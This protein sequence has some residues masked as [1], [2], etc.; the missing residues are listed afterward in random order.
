MTRITALYRGLSPHQIVESLIQENAL[1]RELLPHER[2]ADR[3]LFP[4]PIRSPRNRAYE[5][6]RREEQTVAARRHDGETAVETRT[7]LLHETSTAL[8]QIKNALGGAEAFNALPNL[9][10]GYEIGS[11]HYLDFI[12]VEDLSHSIMKGTDALGRPFISLK[13]QS[14]LSSSSHE[15]FVVT[16]FQRHPLETAWHWSSS[17]RS[18]NHEGPRFNTPLNEPA[19]NEIGQIVSGN[20]PSLSLV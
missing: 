3:R 6:L 1:S 11:T 4:D 16:F 12:R 8:T 9:D 20:H 15:P 2:L 14:R 5:R 19:F 10:I 13:L 18:A 7:R 17:A